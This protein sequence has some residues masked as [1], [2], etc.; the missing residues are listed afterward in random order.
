MDADRAP[1]VES[2]Q[3]GAPYRIVI[4]ARLRRGRRPDLSRRQ[5]CNQQTGDQNESP[6]AFNRS[7][8]NAF[9]F[10]TAARS[11]S[12]VCCTATELFAA[13]FLANTSWISVESGHTIRMYFCGVA[14]RTVRSSGSH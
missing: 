5:R 4:E 8:Q 6:N 2:R 12:F 10:V 11:G 1:R 14:E 7:S 3:R 13:P 9:I